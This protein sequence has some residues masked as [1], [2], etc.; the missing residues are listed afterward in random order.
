HSADYPIARSFPVQ[1]HADG[2]PPGLLPKPRN[3]VDFE[4]QGLARE[5]IAASELKRCLLADE[6]LAV[7]GQ[8]TVAVAVHVEDVAIEHEPD[9]CLR[10]RAVSQQAISRRL[11]SVGWFPGDGA[12]DL[13]IIDRARGGRADKQ[14]SRHAEHG[15]RFHLSLLSREDRSRRARG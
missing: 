11:A 4:G 14:G 8:V 12:L 15:E 1:C 13:G 2:V 7:F 5:G 6:T 10:L 9:S 3:L